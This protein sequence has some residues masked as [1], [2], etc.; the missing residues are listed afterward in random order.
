MAVHDKSVREPAP[1]A[2]AAS[3]APV[4]HAPTSPVDYQPAPLEAHTDVQQAVLPRDPRTHSLPPPVSMSPSTEKAQENS[5]FLNFLQGVGQ[6]VTQGQQPGYVSSDAWSNLA[7]QH[8]KDRS[9]QLWRAIYLP[10]YLSFTSDFAHACS[11]PGM[12]P[13]T[14]TAG[15]LV[16]PGESIDVCALA[17]V[18]LCFP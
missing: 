17:S 1:L 12:S 7:L 3:V 14:P 13:G 18:F 2:V 4:V 11:I 15:K 10:Q 9:S 16:A 5:L 8:R 6:D